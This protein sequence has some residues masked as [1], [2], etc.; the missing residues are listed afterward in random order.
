MAGGCGL[1]HSVEQGPVAVVGAAGGEE[2]L[3]GLGALIGAA[4]VGQIALAVQA[5]CGQGT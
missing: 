1:G 2:D 3:V 5:G 4:L